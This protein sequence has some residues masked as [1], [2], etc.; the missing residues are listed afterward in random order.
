MD[1]L[2]STGHA[3]PMQEVGLYSL[4]IFLTKLLPGTTNTLKPRNSACSMMAPI[5]HLP[6][7]VHMK[8]KSGSHRAW[9]EELLKHCGSRTTFRSVCFLN[10]SK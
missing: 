9:Q 2:S 8:P 4:K 6:H 5:S 3:T 7:L 10:F 1:S